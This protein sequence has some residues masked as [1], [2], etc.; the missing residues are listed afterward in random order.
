MIKCSEEEHLGQ[1]NSN[2]KLTIMK[3]LAN[4]KQTAVLT[5]LKLQSQKYNKSQGDALAFS[6]QVEKVV[7]EK[8]SGWSKFAQELHVLTSITP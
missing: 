7:R 5:K 8:G 6:I 4:I 2:K 1:P 3:P